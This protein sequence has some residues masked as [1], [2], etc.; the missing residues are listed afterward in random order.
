MDKNETSKRQIIKSRLDFYVGVSRN[1]EDLLNNLIAE[2]SDLGIE[3]FDSIF[4]LLLQ[5]G[6]S[7][8][9]LRLN[10]LPPLGDLLLHLDL[11]LLLHL[12]ERG[13]DLSPGGAHDGIGLFL[14]LLDLLGGVLDAVELLPD[15]GV[16][17][18]H[19]FSERGV[20]D[21]VE[22]EHEEKEFQSD[23]GEGEVEVEK[24][25]LFDFDG[26]GRGGVGE[27]NGGGGGGEEGREFG[28]G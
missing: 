11:R 1:R 13:G 6:E 10:L 24:G 16:A 27:G 23:D 5:R 25:G 7:L 15:G 14:E 8:L 3:G 9:Q 22:G 20:V 12:I 2:G 18:V 26:E 17:L 21:L 19:E 4:L 28:E